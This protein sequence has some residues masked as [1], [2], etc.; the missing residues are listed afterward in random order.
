MRAL[1]AEN[2]RDQFESDIGEF[3]HMSS[4]ISEWESTHNHI[5]VT[6]S[7]DLQIIFLI[8]KFILNS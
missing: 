7:L 3:C 2:S 8:N 1:R 4:A 6:H 5:S